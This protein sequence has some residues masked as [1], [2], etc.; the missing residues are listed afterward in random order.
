LFW[1]VSSI[2][3]EN[4]I[5]IRFV[6]KKL[7]VMEA[8]KRKLILDTHVKNPTWSGS[9]IAKSLK[10]VK[11]TVCSV[12][13][14]FREM[15]TIDRQVHTNRYSGTKDRKLHLKVLRTIKANPGQSDYDIAKKFNA[16]RCT[17]RRI[18]LREGIRSYRASKQPNR[19]LKQNVVA[20]GRARK[21]YNKVL[22]KYDGCI[23]MD[24]ETYVKMDFGQLPGQKIYKATGRGDVP[25]KFKFVF[26]DK[27]ARKCLIWQGI[28]S[29]GR[30]TPV[31]VTNKTMDS[32]MY[33]EECLRKRILPYIRSHKG[34]VKFW[35]DLASCHYSKEV[36]QWYRDNGVDFVE[37]DIN[38]PNCP[39][40]RPIEKYWAIVKQK[41]KKNGRTTRDAT[42]MKRW[43]NK[44]AAEVSEQGVQTMMSGIRRK[45]RDFI[46]TTSE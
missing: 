20:K 4:F 35:P 36:L 8:A 34:P 40:F 32:K 14:R 12:L 3:A 42:E 25:G 37:K 44:M 19:T 41:M 16:D 31:F 21:L 28:C 22:T 6:A 38:P 26:A 17:V 30:K 46:K 43:W 39:Q 7:H 13:K 29:C 5:T 2:S 27:F 45:V 1:N 10:M 9:K 33:K 11:S 24:D 23:L 18:R 15:H